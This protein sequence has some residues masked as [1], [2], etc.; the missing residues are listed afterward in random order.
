MPGVDPAETDPLIP[1]TK[2]KGD[3]AED[4]KLNPFEQPGTSSTPGEKW[5]MNPITKPPQEHG[6]HTAKTSFIE[7]RPLG[8]P[9]TSEN[10]KISLANLDLEQQYP[11]YGKNG[12]FLDLFVE[13]VKLKSDEKEIVFVS[14][15]RG[16]AKPLYTGKKAINPQVLK[17]Q[18]HRQILGPTRAELIQQKDEEIEELDKTIQEDT[19]VA[20]DEY[21]KKNPT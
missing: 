21:R 5:E 16:G 3:D 8:K 1:E 12:K 7:G 17:I 6:S 11:E 18:A 13:N 19:R 4:I 15:L 14:G 2:D 10:S 20:N 9:W